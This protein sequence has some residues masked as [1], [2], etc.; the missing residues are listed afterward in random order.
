M[1]LEVVEVSGLFFEPGIDF[2]ETSDGM[3]YIG[4]NL[5]R[6]AEQRAPN[7]RNTRRGRGFSSLELLMRGKIKRGRKVERGS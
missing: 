3:R 7:T 1:C 4:G 5:L 2:N 6:G